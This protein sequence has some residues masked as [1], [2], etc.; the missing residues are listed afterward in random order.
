MI[1]CKNCG[2]ELEENMQYCP[3]CRQRVDM[4]KGKSDELPDTLKLVP[5]YTQQIKAPHKKF[6]WEITSLILL[7]AIIAT[8]IINFIINKKITWSEYPAAISLIIFSYV[9]LFAF[10]QRK[11]FIQ[12][13]AGLILSSV[14]I[15]IVDAL[16][17]GIDWAVDLG[18]PIL[19]AANLIIIGLLRII[20]S[21]KHKGINLLAWGFV[22]A[23]I[24]CI[25][26]EGILSYYQTKSLRL[27]WSIIVGGSIVLV[28]LVLFFVHSRLKKGR[29]LK[30]T[31][32]I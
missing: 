12:L 23:A 1:I 7:S 21:A 9:T 32:H 15:I 2:V 18:I 14:C 11:T 30:R 27:V 13:L 31:F 10:W 20:R 22:G 28:V 5:L 8:F 25:C 17:G 24:L 29:D 6:T 26:I 3:L 16:T 19:L 4:A